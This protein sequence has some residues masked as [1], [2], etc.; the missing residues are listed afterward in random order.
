MKNFKIL[1]TVTSLLI[2]SPFLYAS[3]GPKNSENS[4]KITINSK[5]IDG[6]KVEITNYNLD[7]NSAD[8]LFEEVA[9]KSA[10]KIS[11]A[12]KVEIYEVSDN[13]PL[14][15]KKTEK[16]K[17]QI[18]QK[19]K[20]KS[21]SEYKTI[22][23]DSIRKKHQSA[24]ELFKKHERISLSIVRTIVNG[25]TVSAGLII[26]G[27]LSPLT[28]LSIGFFSGSISG[29]FQYFNA[30]FQTLIDGSPEKNKITMETKKLGAMRVKSY[31]M[32]KWFL[33]EVSI[34]S[35][36]KLFSFAIGSPS[37]GLQVEAMKV[38]KASILATGSQ[39]LWDSTIAT[40]TKIKLKKA[41]ANK[42]LLAKEQRIS[43]IKT[44]GVSMV[45]VF[46]GI[47]S[48]M[49]AQ[50]GSW[51]LGALGATGIVYTLKAWKEGSLKINNE[52]LEVEKRRFSKVNCRKAFLN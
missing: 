37:G 48:L 41:G 45:S 39:G 26:N 18:L 12:K 22:I 51:T 8:N 35:V 44:F 25:G 19:L 34:Y 36:I 4:G 7:K 3:Q 31:Q 30:T 52:K 27:G 16:L 50:V 6:K 2:N 29:F 33:T 11:D 47:L 9:Q 28:S 38:L 15:L 42:E 21:V 17:S 23:T 20:L 1:I 46:G 43:N 13:E 5:E 40:E 10:E 32:T 14:T 49:G 24:N